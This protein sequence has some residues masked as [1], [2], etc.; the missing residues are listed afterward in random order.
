MN[1]LHDWYDDDND[2][3]DGGSSN[4]LLF[5]AMYQALLS[6]SHELIHKILTTITSSQDHFTD[7][8]T[9]RLSHLPKHTYLVSEG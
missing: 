5:S 9:E 4:K 8:E 6:A 1:I 3:T 7:E 2:D